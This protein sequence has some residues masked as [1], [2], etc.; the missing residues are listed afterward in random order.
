[1]Y[2]HEELA[3][4]ALH[5][6]PPY[7]R[8]GAS[9]STGAK[10]PSVGRLLLRTMGPLLVRAQRRALKRAGIEWS[11]VQRD[12]EVDVAPVIADTELANTAHGFFLA[13]GFVRGRGNA[14]VG[15][16]LLGG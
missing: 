2:A 13:A 12:G 4:A 5:V 3:L 9:S 15:I 16:T 10:P 11:E 7:R 1:M 8:L 6:T 14:W